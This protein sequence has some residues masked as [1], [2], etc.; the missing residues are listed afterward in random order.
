MKDFI[1]LDLETPNRYSNSISSI[2]IVV[3][4]D[5]VVVDEIYSLINPEA[6]FDNFNIALT[7]IHPEDVVDAPTFPEF[8]DE[9]RGL[10]QRNI[11]VGQ[12]ITFDLGVISRSLTRYNM[13]IPPFKYYCTLSS[14]KRNLC[15]P[16]NSLSYVVANVLKTTY[17]AHNAMA[18]ARMTYELYNYL[19]DYE[20]SR[21]NFL[22][23][24]YYRPNRKRDFNRTFDYNYNYLYGLT[25]KFSYINEISENHKRL[26]ETWLQSNKYQ[27]AHPLIENILL[28]VSYI[29]HNNLTKHE[30]R[31]INESL[32]AIK[33]SPEYNVNILK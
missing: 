2:G 28:K 30:I 27:N 19:D 14:C 22:K 24:Y 29:I 10:L 9:I 11:I 13:P 15:L 12:N 7:G 33:R 26:M 32:N 17:D 16:D 25:K 5:N 23:T 21:E 20:D 18:D 3:V 6:S 31:E 8:Y 1:V 4:E